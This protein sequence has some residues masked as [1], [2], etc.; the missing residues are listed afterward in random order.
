MIHTREIRYCVLV[1]VFAQSC[2]KKTRRLSK[3]DVQM[4]TSHEATY[5]NKF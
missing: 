2:V 4:S 3:T 1:Q 5:K